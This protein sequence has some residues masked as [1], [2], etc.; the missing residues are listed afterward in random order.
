MERI[1]PLLALEKKELEQE[2]EEVQGM[3]VSESDV[4]VMKQAMLNLESNCREAEPWVTKPFYSLQG[5][6]ITQHELD[7]LQ[8]VEMLEEQNE[9]LRREL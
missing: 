9:G 6:F 2:D 7:L 3:L 5:A 1:Q 8:Q 4:E